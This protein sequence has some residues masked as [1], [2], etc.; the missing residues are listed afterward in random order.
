MSGHTV[1]L[2]GGGQAPAWVGDPT[3]ALGPFGSGGSLLL[4]YA[5]NDTLPWNA[6]GAANDLRALSFA[7]YMKMT[8]AAPGDGYWVWRFTSS[9]G[10]GFRVQL[11]NSGRVRVVSNWGAGDNTVESTTALA[12]G[13]Q[14]M[15]C[16]TRGRAIGDK[17]RL[18]VNGALEDD[19][20]LAN[21][22]PRFTTQPRLYW[23]A[24]NEGFTGGTGAPA[25]IGRTL[26]YDGELSAPQVAGIHLANRVIYPGLPAL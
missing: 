5:I 2:G 26:L 14:A 15:C 20:T 4:K 7:W 1:T 13:Q 25:I 17:L 19:D 23:G 18:Y 22:I 10:G 24:D 3:R 6:G 8:S 16:F 11:W 12:S 21:D 9:G